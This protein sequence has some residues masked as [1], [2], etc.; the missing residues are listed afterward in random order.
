MEFESKKK[1]NTFELSDMIDDKQL[2]LLQFQTNSERTIEQ[3]RED[4][5]TYA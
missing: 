3:R 4:N 1:S 2:Q 5:Q